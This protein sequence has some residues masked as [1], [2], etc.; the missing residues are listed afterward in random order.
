[1]RGD[2]SE[3]LKKWVPSSL[4]PSMVASV[5]VGIVKLVGEMFPGSR[6]SSANA[7]I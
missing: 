1:M 6:V 7:V 2:Q 5:E 3:I 4:A